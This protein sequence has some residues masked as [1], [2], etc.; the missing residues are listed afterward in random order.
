MSNLVAIQADAADAVVVPLCE[1]CVA[2]D[3]E[4]GAVAKKFWNTP[5]LVVRKATS[6]VNPF[7]V[8]H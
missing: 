7:G 6:S 1:P 5:D 8:L 4:A 2:A 3:E